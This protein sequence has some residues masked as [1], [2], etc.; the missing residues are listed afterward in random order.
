M[1]QSETF[2][3]MYV[4]I[5]I[6]ATFSVKRIDQTD[7]YDGHCLRAYS[8]F[9]DK[10][11]DIRLADDRRVFRIKNGIDEITVLEGDEIETPTGTIMK[12][13]DYVSTIGL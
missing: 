10:M 12:I 11:P 2:N 4:E 5:P 8:Y 6:D 1:P 7:G 9:G 13:E 3:Y